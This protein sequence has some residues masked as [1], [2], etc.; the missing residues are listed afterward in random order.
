MKKKITLDEVFRELRGEFS[1]LFYQPSTNTIGNT[2]TFYKS[3]EKRLTEEEYEKIGNSLI[4]IKG[5]K[6]EE[7]KAIMSGFVHSCV[8][9]K[10]QR[11]KLFNALRH[12]TDFYNRFED[13][14]KNFGIYEE[15]MDFSED[16]YIDIAKD[17]YEENVG[18]KKTM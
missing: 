5:L 10:E 15:Y 4:F 16:I 1:G 12:H 18:T 13:A 2:A 7:H 8:E 9:D 14:C 17:W 11:K 6:H 3:K